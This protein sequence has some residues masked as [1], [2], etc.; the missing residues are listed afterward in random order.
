MFIINKNKQ[1]NEAEFHSRERPPTEDPAG[2]RLSLIYGGWRAGGRGEEPTQL[3]IDLSEGQT[4]SQS[5]TK[6]FQLLSRAC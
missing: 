1:N 6:S 4:E 3:F 2:R 5:A